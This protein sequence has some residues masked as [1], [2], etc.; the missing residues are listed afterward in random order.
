PL[1]LLTTRVYLR[2]RGHTVEEISAAVAIARYEGPILL[3]HGDADRVVPITHLQRL[4]RAARAARADDPGGAPVETLILPGGEHSWS[5]ESPVYRAAVARFLATFLGGPL[6]P[7]EAARVAA[8]THAE[9]IPDGEVRFSAIDETTGG[10]R[11]LAQVAMPGATRVTIDDA[12]GRIAAAA[13]E[14]GLG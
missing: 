14:P 3:A 9:R 8:G 10:F 2:P 6:V 5:Y 1:A 7:E 4:A 12:S 11:T 13:D